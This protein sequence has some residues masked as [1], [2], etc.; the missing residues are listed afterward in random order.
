MVF[1]VE[2][3]I[4]RVREHLESEAPHQLRYACLELRYALE[5][6]AYHKLRNR[7]DKVSPEEISA[8]QP[9]RVMKILME[10][11]DEH[12]DRDYTLRIAEEIEPGVV[13]EKG[14][15][16]LGKVKGISPRELGGHWHK[17]GFYLHVQKPKEKGDMPTEP[18]AAE[19]KTY[20]EE[21][22]KY[23]EE[24][25]ETQFD[26]HFSLS[27]TFECGKCNQTIVRNRKLLKHRTVIQCQNPNCNASYIAKVENDEISVDLNK[28]RLD[29][30]NC[31]KG[32]YFDAND[33]L[34]LK[35]NERTSAT[36]DK[37]GTRYIVRWGLEYTLES[38]VD[39][40]CKPKNK[41]YNPIKRAVRRFKRA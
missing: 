36:C 23:V 9:N 40:K 5:R 19:L 14:F 8:W 18:D 33:F 3:Y 21:V 13:S 1:R 41:W 34:E 37:C 26:A 10:L 39:E 6:I 32:T 35:I 29:C 31:E 4:E 27:A 15:S 11:V 25:T 16:T 17:I 20:L 24:I 2:P 22:V 12:I 28:I 7:L 30:K 38:D